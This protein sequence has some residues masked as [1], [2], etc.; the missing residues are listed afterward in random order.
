[1]FA[2]R[3]PG[4]R[5]GGNHRE[6]ER[7]MLSQTE[8]NAVLSKAQELCQVILNQPTMVTARQQIEAFWS[9]EAARAQYQG[10]VTKSQSLQQKQEN[11]EELAEAEISDFQTHRE[12]VMSNP[13]SKGF[14]EAQ[15]VMR[16]LHHS[17]T[18]VVSMT[19]ENGK[20]PSLDDLEEASCGHGCNC[21]H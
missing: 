18:K 3:P 20:V 13:V 11:N 10:L 12:Q 19:L 2:V 17:V 9:D 14:L 5:G 7:I 1:M 4:G 6:F 8:Q 15:E 16:G 21:S